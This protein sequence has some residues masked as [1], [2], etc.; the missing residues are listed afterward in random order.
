MSDINAS[1]ASRAGKERSD[2]DV[3]GRGAG[4]LMVRS[5]GKRGKQGMEGGR[6]ERSGGA[7][8]KSGEENARRLRNQL[9][10]MAS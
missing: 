8:G 7:V 5:T 3:G 10:S 4:K 9:V 2:F 1:G 6:E